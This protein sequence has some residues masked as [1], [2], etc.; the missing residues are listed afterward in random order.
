MV[1]A[2]ACCILLT[3][4]AQAAGTVDV[5]YDGLLVNL[6]ERGIGPAFNKAS[7][8]QFQ[9]YAGGSKLNRTGFPGGNLLGSGGDGRTGDLGIVARLGFGGRNVADGLEQASM[10]E[11]VHPLEGSELHRLVGL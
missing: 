5:L 1:V 4:A 6:M 10:V 2:I 7:G 9:G 8:G 3:P 11:P